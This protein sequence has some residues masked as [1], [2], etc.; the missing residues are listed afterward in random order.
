MSTFERTGSPR[1]RGFRACLAMA[2]FLAAGCAWGEDAAPAARLRADFAAIREATVDNPFRRALYL[3]SS[4]GV[5]GVSGVVYAVLDHP[6]AA[7]APVFANPSDWCEILAL[8]P[9]TK[10]CRSTWESPGAALDLRVGTK[11]DQPLADARRLAFR[12]RVSALGADYLAARLS[13]DEGPLDTRDYRIV[14]EAVP[15][16]GGRTL[17]RLAY[18]YGY[19]TVGRVAMQV[20]LATAGRDKVGFTT[21]GQ[22]SGGRPRYVAGLR[23]VVERNTMRYGL[24]IEAYLGARA[25]PVA[26]RREKSLRDWFAATER[27]ARQLHEMELGDYLAL[28]RKEYARQQAQ[29]R[30]GPG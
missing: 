27:H 16:E 12:Y 29:D 14:L 19:G 1:P 15:A 17:I 11:H 26:E 3:R 9:N 6:F 2:F 24:A 10:Y 8:H 18:S 20:Y 13:A 25:L 23:G 4:E 7:T 22:D 5:G 30:A 21:T 28:K